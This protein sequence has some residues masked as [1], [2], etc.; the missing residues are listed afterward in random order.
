MRTAA[1]LRTG[2]PN[3]ASQS[4]PPDGVLHGGSVHNPPLK[5]KRLKQRRWGN[6]LHWCAA[7]WVSHCKKR[8]VEQADDV[9]C[10]RARR[11]GDSAAA[12]DPSP[13]SSRGFKQSQERRRRYPHA[14]GIKSWLVRRRG[15]ARQVRDDL[16]GRPSPRTVRQ[17]LPGPLRTAALVPLPPVS[18]R[19]EGSSLRSE[20]SATPS[21]ASAMAL[22]PLNRV[23]GV[24]SR[25]SLVALPATRTRDQQGV[26]RD[27]N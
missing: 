9:W 22:V 11:P 5:I 21:V 6:R 14:S 18:T 23:D 25:A 15:T 3:R 17:S 13:E 19:S 24:R 1:S 27:A 12:A 4:N 20:N 7:W 16:D 8:G 26:E 2:P 10:V